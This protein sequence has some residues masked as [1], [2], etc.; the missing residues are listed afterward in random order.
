[1][2]GRFFDTAEV[3]RYA[4]WIVS[5][6]K[7]ALPSGFDSSSKKSAEQAQK[8][9]ERIDKR[10]AEF[11]Q[12]VALN[13]YKKAHLA[14]RVREGM[15]AHGYSEPFVKSFSYDLLGRIQLASNRRG[16]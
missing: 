13:I 10:T 6:L 14:A 3:D 8:L 12:T 11:T 4:D 16:R 1:M 2:F 15:N 7:R 9:N 5:E